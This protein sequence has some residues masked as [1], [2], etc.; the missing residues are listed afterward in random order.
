MATR[1]LA[2]SAVEIA[3]ASQVLPTATEPVSPTSRGRGG[4]ASNRSAIA[5]ASTKDCVIAETEL[6]SLPNGKAEMS[7]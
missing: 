4:N 7:I 3:S 6:Q 2:E 5:D 1:L